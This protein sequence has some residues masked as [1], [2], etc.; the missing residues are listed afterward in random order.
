ML[1]LSVVLMLPS[2]A[3]SVST[4]GST[5][6]LSVFTV[7]Y[8]IETA[9]SSVLF[10]GLFLFA[11][12]GFAFY[13]TRRYTAGSDLEGEPKQTVKIE[14]AKGPLPDEIKSLE[15]NYILKTFSRTEANNNAVES[16]LSYSIAGTVVDDKVYTTGDHQARIYSDASLSKYIAGVGASSY[17]LYVR[18]YP[19]YFFNSLVSLQDY[20]LVRSLLTVAYEFIDFYFRVLEPTDLLRSSKLYTKATSGLKKFVGIEG[21][22]RPLPTL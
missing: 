3:I 2:S 12:L 4:K 1:F 10:V 8:F 13:R 15:S 21:P 16:C 17:P 5:A 18:V 7:P 22:N 9:L 14:Y 20:R 6:I 19:K 11:Y